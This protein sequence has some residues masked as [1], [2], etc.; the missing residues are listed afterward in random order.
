[1]TKLVLIFLLVTGIIVSGCINEDVSNILVDMQPTPEPTQ[2]QSTEPE[3]DQQQ[4]TRIVESIL[5]KDDLPSFK[6]DKHVKYYVPKSIIMAIDTPDR[7]EIK[8]YTKYVPIGN[9]HYGSTMEY[10]DNYGRTITVM[11]VILDSNEGVKEIIDNA[12]HNLSLYKV[13]EA[14]IGDYSFWTEAGGEDSALLVSFVQFSAGNNYVMVFTLDE[15]ESGHTLAEHVA[16]KIES[17]LR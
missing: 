8:E 2:I 1:M 5:V 4:Y 15:V 7:Y 12:P 16:R 6:L 14:D 11:H 9:R 10:S 17:M 3:S 13:G